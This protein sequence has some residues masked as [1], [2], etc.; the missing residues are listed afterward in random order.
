MCSKRKFDPDWISENEVAKDTTLCLIK[1]E[2][3][4]SSYLGQTPRGELYYNPGTVAVLTRSV[5]GNGLLSTVPATDEYNGGIVL[6]AAP[7]DTCPAYL[8]KGTLDLDTSVG[9]RWQGLGKVALTWTPSS[10]VFLNAM[11]LWSMTMYY[12]LAQLLYLPR[13]SVRVIPVL[14]SKSMVGVAVLCFACYGNRNVQVLTTYLS[15]D[16]VTKLN[17]EPY[18]LSGPL[19]IASVIGI[20]SST[21]IQIIFNPYLA[22]PSFVLTIVSVANFFIIFHPRSLRVPLPISHAPQAVCAGYIKCMLRLQCREE[23]FLPFSDHCSLCR[24]A[25]IRCC[26]SAWAMPEGARIN[27]QKQSLNFARRQVNASVDDISKR[28]RVCVTRWTCDG[29]FWSPP[30]QQLHP[31]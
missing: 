19:M 4:I 7:W 24:T 22:V 5:L 13:S 11:T 12:G 20:M 25:W 29:R 31:R 26:G 8:C 14:M 15:L 30:L 16:K 3:G 2:K 6:S 17:S 28:M 10:L 1:I 18:R 27:T 9:M 23:N 21:A